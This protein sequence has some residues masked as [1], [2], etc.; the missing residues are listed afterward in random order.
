MGRKK[1]EDS[2]YYLQREISAS[3]MQSLNPVSCEPP[4][5][6]VSGRMQV[7]F[8]GCRGARVG[9]HGNFSPVIL[10]TLYP[11]EL[12]E[13]EAAVAY[14]STEPRFNVDKNN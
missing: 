13:S 5:W 10:F 9:L 4:G 14:D 1:R 2:N 7:R 3:F 12:L 6:E 8:R 11:L